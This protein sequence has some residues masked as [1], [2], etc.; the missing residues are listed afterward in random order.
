MDYEPGSRP[1]PD[2]ES[3]MPSSWTAYPPDMREINVFCLSHHAI[4]FFLIA[5]LTKMK[6]LYSVCRFSS[7]DLLP[8]HKES[9]HPR[10]ETQLV[11]RTTEPKDSSSLPGYYYEGS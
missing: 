5:S 6:T 4:V 1:S 7:E 2:T 11:M 9:S 8:L 10:E 3:A